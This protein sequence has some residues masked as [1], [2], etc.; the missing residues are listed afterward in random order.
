[1]IELVLHDQGTLTVL[2]LYRRLQVS[3]YTAAGAAATAGANRALTELQLESLQNLQNKRCQG[4][5]RKAPCTSKAAK[6]PLQT[7]AERD[8]LL[9]PVKPYTGFG[10]CPRSSAAS[11][12]WPT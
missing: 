2:T 8:E 5:R 3:N 11:K 1:M 7:D 10:D 9:Q 12:L 6:Q 4:C